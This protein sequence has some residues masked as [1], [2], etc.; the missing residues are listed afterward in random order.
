MVR[1]TCQSGCC[2]SVRAVSNGWVMAIE[3]HTFLASPFVPVA[4]GAASLGMQFEFCLFNS[5]FSPEIRGLTD[6][7]SL[8]GL[9]QLP[10]AV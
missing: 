4:L 8:L 9:A 7:V 10:A 6:A 2:L 1:G 3:Q 5:L